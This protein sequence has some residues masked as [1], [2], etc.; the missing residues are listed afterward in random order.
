MSN[1]IWTLA[2]KM[3][4][5][6]FFRKCFCALGLGLRIGLGVRV[7]VEV[8]VSR[9]TFKYVFGQTSI[10]ASVLDPCSTYCSKS[11]LWLQSNKQFIKRDVLQV[12][13]SIMEQCGYIK[14]AN[15][16]VVFVGKGH[17][18]ECLTFE[19]LNRSRWQLD[20]KTVKSHSTILRPTGQ[21]KLG[22]ETSKLCLRIRND[23]IIYCGN[24]IFH[25]RIIKKELIAVRRL[26]FYNQSKTRVIFLCTEIRN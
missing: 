20:S 14:L 26:M 16:L 11:D 6:S 23:T 17:L 15:S 9:N 8:R 1:G 18:V 25:F 4:S 5:F 21:E 10:R 24:L 12:H 13:M 22:V 2:R 7:K 3:T 19:W